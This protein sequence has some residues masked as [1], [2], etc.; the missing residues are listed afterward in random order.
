MVRASHSPRG[1]D[2]EV[3]QL[4]V[5]IAVA[6]LKRGTPPTE[7]KDPRLSLNGPLGLWGDCGEAPGKAHQGN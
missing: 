4:G 7:L 6:E 5:D 1:P 3:P 2:Q